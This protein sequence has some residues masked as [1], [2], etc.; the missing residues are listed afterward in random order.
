[1]LLSKINSYKP[2]I[3][4]TKFKIYFYLK[5][6]ENSAD[7]VLSFAKEIN[8]TDTWKYSGFLIDIIIDLSEIEKHIE[9]CEKNAFRVE[10]LDK[11]ECNEYLWKIEESLRD[12]IN[13]NFAILLNDRLF[14]LLLDK[15]DNIA[16][17]PKLINFYSNITKVTES[18]KKDLNN[19][20]IIIAT[21]RI[22]YILEWYSKEI[23]AK[24]IQKSPET[25]DSFLKISKLLNDID[26]KTYN[27][28]CL[29]KI[30]KTYELRSLRNNK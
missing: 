29:K 17:F 2:N 6:I 10:L 16:D 11:E 18:Y 7:Y 19:I 1:M 15:N 3:K 24:D 12:G 23:I 27:L 9:K 14:T 5:L 28:F 25:E 8:S 30:K 22:R 4:I 20:S 26:N 13:S 21:A